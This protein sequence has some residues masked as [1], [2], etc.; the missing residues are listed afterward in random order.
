M[1]T[2]GFSKDG[3]HTEIVDSADANAITL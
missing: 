2:N 1:I 3:Y